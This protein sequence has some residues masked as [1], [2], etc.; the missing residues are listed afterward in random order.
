MRIVLPYPF[1]ALWPN[2]RPHWSAKARATRSYRFMAKLAANGAKPGP[3]HLVFCPRPFGPAP[4]LD[5]CIAAFKA[6][7]D[8]LADAMGVNDRD[9]TFTYVIGNRCKEG[10]VI[11]EIGE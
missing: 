6:G 8:G 9:L 5:N 10:A 1:P 2:K 4:D 7:Q 11:V 3:V